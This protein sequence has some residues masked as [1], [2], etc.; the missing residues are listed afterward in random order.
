MKQ[1]T[2]PNQGTA[3]SVSDK[4]SQHVNHYPHHGDVALRTRLDLPAKAWLVADAN[5][6]LIKIHIIGQQQVNKFAWTH[7]REHQS[8]KQR[9][10]PYITCAEKLHFLFSCE[11]D[12][13]LRVIDGDPVQIK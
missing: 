12:D 6:A 9:D 11:Y 3:G 7:A 5:H 4:S 13:G 1:S 8:Q 10:L 2:S